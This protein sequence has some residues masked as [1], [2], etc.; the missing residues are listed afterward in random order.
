MTSN[1]KYI[2][3]F[4]PAPINMSYMQMDKE[5]QEI[6][7][8]GVFSIKDSTN[9]GSCKKLMEHLDKLNFNDSTVLHEQQPRCNIKTITICGQLQMYFVM[10]KIDG[11]NIDKIVG[12]HAGNKN[13]YYNGEE[14]MPDRINKLKKSHYKNKQISIEHCRRI[15]KQKKEDSKWVEFFEKNKKKD[16]LADSYLMALSYLNK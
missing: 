13:K 3:S 4:D 1:T 15:M 14:P 10:K 11:Y 8:W 12:Y 6:V 16:D 7:Q 9:E 2:V 5:T